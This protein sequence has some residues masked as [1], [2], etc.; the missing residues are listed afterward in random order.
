MVNV[1]EVVS[2]NLTLS[3]VRP[4]FQGCIGTEK[5]MY[6][7]WE[8]YSESFGYPLPLPMITLQSFSFSD[9]SPHDSDHVTDHTSYSQLP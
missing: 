9:L 5:D 2:E 1:G 3:Q 7:H 4:F 6:A 8:D